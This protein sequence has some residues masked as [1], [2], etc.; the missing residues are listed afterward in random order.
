MKPLPSA[1][2][3]PCDGG[4]ARV[5]VVRG[6]AERVLFIVRSSVVMQVAGLL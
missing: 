1:L 5:F 6:Q 2:D 3:Q 4:A